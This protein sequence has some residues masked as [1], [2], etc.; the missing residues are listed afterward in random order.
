MAKRR[1]ND[2]T[3]AESERLAMLAEESAEVIQM[4]GKTLRH[5]YVSQHPDGGPI[6][7]ALLRK[8]IVD[9]MAVLTLMVDEND[10]IPLDQ[11]EVDEAIK[12]KLTYTHH[13]K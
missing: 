9:F 4:V 10:F 3:E 11:L 2:L 13:Q 5:G 8:E 6:N 1:P 12:R 7:R